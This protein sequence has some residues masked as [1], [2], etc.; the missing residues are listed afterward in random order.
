VNVD[1]SLTGTPGTGK[2][3]VAE[4]LE[5]R[6]HGVA[7]LNQLLD[8]RG[9]G[10]LEKVREVDVEEMRERLELDVEV[11]EG[12]LSHFL[13]ADVCVVLRCRPDVLGERL[14]GRSY[15]DEKVSENLKAEALDVVLQ[16]SVESQETVVEIDTTDKSVPEVAD[17]VE[18]AFGTRE[19]SYGGVDFSEFL[20]RV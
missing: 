16:Q 9:I 15:S 4:E 5:S 3:S 7:H 19:S 2:T 20:G 6:S 12:H 13:S 8:Q 17:Q 11:V 18:A 10:A 14:S 1:L